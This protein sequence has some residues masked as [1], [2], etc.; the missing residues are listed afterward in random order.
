MYPEESRMNINCQKGSVKHRLPLCGH[1][2]HDKLNVIEVGNLDQDSH[3][4]INDAAAV[5]LL[6]PAFLVVV[7]VT[8]SIRKITL[9]TSIKTINNYAT[10]YINYN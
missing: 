4:L 1:V 3:Q 7:P 5:F 9:L 8:E 2:P 10:C 6:F